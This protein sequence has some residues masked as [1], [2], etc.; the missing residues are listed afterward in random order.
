[1]KRGRPRIK[2]ATDPD[3]YVLAL[4]HVFR[5]MGA[6]RR[7]AIEIAVACMEGCVIGPNQWPGRGHG[8]TMLDLS[9]ELPGHTFNANGI[10][11]RARWLRRKMKTVVKDENDA[12]GRWLAVMSAAWWIALYRGPE[13]LILQLAES[14]GELAYAHDVLLPVA[15]GRA[16]QRRKKV[17]GGEFSPPNFSIVT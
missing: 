10:A 7:G 14:V 1:M 6:S 3:R 15:S 17:P 11:D 12:S 8:L 4:A 9:Y 16:V 13:H 5:E 2:F